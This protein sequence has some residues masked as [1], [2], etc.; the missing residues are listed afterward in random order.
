MLLAHTP[1]VRDCVESSIERVRDL[2]E[3]ARAE[4][5]S[6][7]LPERFEYILVAIRGIHEK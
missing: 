5:G 2:P 7:E 6:P 3:V 1:A 4:C